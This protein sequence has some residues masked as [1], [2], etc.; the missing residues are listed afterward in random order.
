MITTENKFDIKKRRVFK[1]NLL[2]LLST[3]GRP[4]V[5]PFTKIGNRGGRSARGRMI[6]GS[7]LYTEFERSTGP[8][9]ENAQKEVHVKSKISGSQTNKWAT[10]S[11]R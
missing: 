2:W 7:A 6:W 4:L 11:Q 9:D 8:A 1:N 3:L 5:G 10:Q